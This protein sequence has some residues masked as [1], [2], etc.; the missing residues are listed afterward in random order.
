M[1][2]AHRNIE[3]LRALETLCDEINTFVVWLET[4]H[5]IALGYIMESIRRAGEYSGDISEN[6]INYLAEHEQPVAVKRKRG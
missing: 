6:V 4:P 1:K 5:A 3:S 2:K